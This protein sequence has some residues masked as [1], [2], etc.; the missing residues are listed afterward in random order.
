MLYQEA[1]D[2]INEALAPDSLTPLQS[3]V[4]KWILENDSY[5][6][7]APKL[8][9]EY[10]YLKD[11]GA[12]LC[13]LL[14]RTF[15]FKVTKL[16]L[17][18]SL[19]RYVEQKQM[20]NQCASLP[21]NCVDCREALA[22]QPADMGQSRSVVWVSLQQTPILDLFPDLMSAIAHRQLPQTAPETAMRQLL[23][24]LRDRHCLLI[25]DDVEE[26]AGAIKS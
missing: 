5:V 26:V 20:R 14:S 23:E 15:G 10:S 9:H 22:Q 3:G 7:M 16:S 4:L 8:H 1:L 18:S 12:D 2:T 13:K 19:V 11:I 6:Q 21:R 17:H 24:Q 25:L